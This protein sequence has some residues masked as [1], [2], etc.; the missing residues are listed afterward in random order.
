MDSYRIGWKGRKLAFIDCL[1]TGARI[2]RFEPDADN[3]F[4]LNRGRVHAQQPDEVLKAQS[5][6]LAEVVRAARL[7]GQDE[8]KHASRST[9]AAPFKPFSFNNL[10]R[11]KLLHR[12]L[13]SRCCDT[14]RQRKWPQ[15]KTRRSHALLDHPS[16]ARQLGQSVAVLRGGDGKVCAK[17]GCRVLRV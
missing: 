13:T 16:W 9:Q 5:L 1:D 3:V 11:P 14:P 8:P 6:M 12:Q 15:G 2:V 7:L 10:I 17:V 4:V